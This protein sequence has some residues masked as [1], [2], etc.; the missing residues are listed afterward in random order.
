MEV[1]ASFTCRI[2]VYDA[3]TKTKTLNLHFVELSKN[4]IVKM[5]NLFD[6]LIR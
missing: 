1:S 4:H 6:N 2:K 3:F 5:L